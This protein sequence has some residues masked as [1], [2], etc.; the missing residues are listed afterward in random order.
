MNYM[1]NPWI[2]VGVAVVLLFGI[3]IWLSGQAAEQNN[4]GVEINTHQKGNPEARV[5]LTEFSD[6]QCPACRAAQPVIADVLAAFPDDVRLDFRFFPLPT[7]PFSLQAAQAAA[8]AGQQDKFFEFHDILFERQAEW[9][10]SGSPSVL[11]VRYAE[12]LGLDVDLFRRHMRSSVLRDQVV[13]DRNEGIER[14][15]TGTPT[16]FLNGERMQFASYE[17]FFQQVA[18]AV[19]P[20][21]S[22][23]ATGEGGTT[24]GDGTST[25]APAAGEVRFG[26]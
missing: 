19:D 15:V 2:I 4:E 12:E 18:Q 23:E 6:F 3:A 26:I 17:E 13:A 9:S 24:T 1:K 22:F 5:V 10:G 16:F 25:D 14:G 8:A 7:F 20:S 11:F 21:V